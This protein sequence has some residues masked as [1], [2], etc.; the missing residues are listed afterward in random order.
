MIAVAVLLL[1]MLG[2][3]LYAMDRIEEGLRGRPRVARH[4]KGHH[5]RLIH[6][7]SRPAT[8][9]VAAGRAPR[10]LDAA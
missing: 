3:L 2:L 4:A 9:R 5:L 1:L 8:D 6:S 7:M 10:R